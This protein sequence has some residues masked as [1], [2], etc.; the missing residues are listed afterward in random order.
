MQ[1]FI[2]VGR[3]FS[4]WASKLQLLHACHNEISVCY[5]KTAL[6]KKGLFGIPFFPCR[7]TGHL[8]KNG[9]IPLKMGCLVALV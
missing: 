8:L 7:K 6:L 1:W 2:K 9:A 3:L 4:F 5:K